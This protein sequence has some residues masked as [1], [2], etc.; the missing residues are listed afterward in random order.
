M[1]NVLTMSSEEYVGWGR[2]SYN[3]FSFCNVGCK[4]YG[5]TL[6]GQK[7]RRFLFTSGLGMYWILREFRLY[8]DNTYLPWCFTWIQEFVVNPSGCVNQTITMVFLCV[9]SPLV[10]VDNDNYGSTT[11]MVVVCNPFFM[12]WH[13]SIKEW[14]VVVAQKKRWVHNITMIFS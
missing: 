9:A 13:N 3:S 2:V 14:I 4:T 6:S 7:I 12:S 5:Q 8:L 11:V 1:V 10:N